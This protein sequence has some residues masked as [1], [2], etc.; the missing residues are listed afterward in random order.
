MFPVVC[1]DTCLDISTLITAS[2]NGA[3]IATNLVKLLSLADFFQ[4][5][6]LEPEIL[7]IL[8]MYLDEKACVEFCVLDPE[9][10][11]EDWHRPPSPPEWYD[12]SLQDLLQAMRA[13]YELPGCERVRKSLVAFLWVTRL[14]GPIMR[15]PS[16]RSLLVE[17]PE[18][19]VDLINIMD[20][21][22]GDTDLYY[23]PP[24]WLEGLNARCTQSVLRQKLEE[25][26]LHLVRNDSRCAI[27]GRRLKALNWD[28]RT[29]RN[30]FPMV[31]G[32]DNISGDLVVKHWEIGEF[33]WCEHCH[34]DMKQRGTFPPWRAEWERD[35]EL[36]CAIHKTWS[37]P[38]SDEGLVVED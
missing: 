25:G 16:V 28:A 36:W 17:V 20:H 18:V 24:F 19:A 22:E 31:Y 30:P 21:F 37:S 7:P 2:Q 10:Y 13:A 38:G 15:L 32:R 1:A 29:F 5:H 12:S 8:S 3:S 4:I 14:A 9:A 26:P 33:K 6:T 34:H 35:V 11:Y 23:N 27:C